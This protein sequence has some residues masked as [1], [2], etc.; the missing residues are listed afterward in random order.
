MECVSDRRFSKTKI[1]TARDT[2]ELFHSDDI[3]ANA[4]RR[5]MLEEIPTIAI[6]F[7][8]IKVNTSALNT[9]GILIVKLRRGE[10]LTLRALAHKGLGKNHA[11]W[12][13]ATTITFKGEPNIYINDE[14][15]ETLM[16]QEK[17][18]FAE[19]SPHLF[20]YDPPFKQICVHYYWAGKCYDEALKKAEAMG[21]PGLVEIHASEDNFIFTV[22]STGALKTSQL[23]LSALKYL[24][25][26]LDNVAL[27]RHIVEESDEE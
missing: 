7:V 18:E 1:R 25:E 17:K 23:V 14:L 19:S 10:K 13:P 9:R 5:V 27:S 20:Y 2:F 3:T 11:R 21:I 15:M 24:R 12:S 16:I 8:E 26:K 4:L 22:E 6:D